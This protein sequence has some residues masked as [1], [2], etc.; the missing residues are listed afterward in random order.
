MHIHIWNTRRLSFQPWSTITLKF[1][2]LDIFSCKLYIEFKQTKKYI[3][4]KGKYG[5]PKQIR[6]LFKIK[7]KTEIY[8]QMTNKQKHIQN[9]E[10]K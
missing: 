7:M 1:N 10:K 3:K 8:K 9:H 4:F 6:L 2:V 5:D